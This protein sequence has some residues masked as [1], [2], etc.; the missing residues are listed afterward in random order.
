M[1]TGTGRRTAGAVRCEWSP[2]GRGVPLRSTVDTAVAPKPRTHSGSGPA[3]GRPVKN[4]AAMQPPRQASYAP[5]D[6][7]A[8]GDCGSRRDANSVEDRQTAVKPP[9]SRTDPARKASWMAKGQA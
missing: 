8:P 3:S 9:G 7:Q 5:Q 1:V 6:A 4:F 2:S